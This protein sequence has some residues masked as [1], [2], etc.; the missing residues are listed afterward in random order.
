VA[1]FTKAGRDCRILTLSTHSRDSRPSPVPVKLLCYVH[2]RVVG[3]Y[4]RA[5]PRAKGRLSSNCKYDAF[6]PVDVAWTL[7][8]EAG[9]LQ[10]DAALLR[11]PAVALA[12][13]HLGNRSGIAVESHAA[14]EPCVELIEWIENTRLWHTRRPPDSQRA[15]FA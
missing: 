14:R 12:G 13:A 7:S 6:V 11:E 4:G 15:R 9:R 3:A 1:L 8:W 2:S 10:P 5:I